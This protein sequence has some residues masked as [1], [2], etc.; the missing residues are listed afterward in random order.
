[1]DPGVGQDIQLE[2]D[3][4]GIHDKEFNDTSGKVTKLDNVD[5]KQTF[6]IQLEENGN[7]AHDEEFNN[8]TDNELQRSND[9]S[10]SGSSA[11]IVSQHENF[12]KMTPSSS[13]VQLAAVNGD[14][15]FVGQ[16]FESE[17]AAH[18][19]YSAYGMRLGFITRI[20]YN[21][22]SKRDGSVISRAIVCNKEGYRKPSRHE[23]KNIRARAPT[24]VGC[25]AMLS[26]RK[27]RSG[28]WVVTKFVKEHTH[29]L[30]GGQAQKTL[31]CNQIAVEDM[32]IH[33]LTQ[34]LLVEKKRSTSLKRC[35]DLL[36]NH[37]EE[38]TQGLS[39]K[40]QYI[41]DSVNMI[42]SEGKA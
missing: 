17:A 24:R 18:A 3:D 12:E 11:E 6:D 10:V 4:N 36:F 42:E 2:E 15:P 33:K 38:H 34:E 39:K 9:S 20:H 35:I 19:F 37:I 16:E 7:D 8:S 25:K 32:R 13:G 1:M 14:E 30:A 31:L 22:R 28:N 21:T 5:S 29:L 41:V 23:V 27:V 40:I 26:V